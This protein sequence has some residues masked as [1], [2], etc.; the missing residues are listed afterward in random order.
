MRRGRKI[1]YGTGGEN[2]NVNPKMMSE[3]VGG[4]G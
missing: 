2:I 1:L 4:N 3:V